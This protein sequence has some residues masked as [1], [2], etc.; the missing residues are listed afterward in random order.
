MAKVHCQPEANGALI[1]AASMMYAV[2][3]RPIVAFI[4]FQ[5]NVSS[6]YWMASGVLIPALICY[7]WVYVFY[8]IVVGGFAFTLMPKILLWV[9]GNRAKTAAAPEPVQTTDYEQ[10]L[11]NGQQDKANSWALFWL[12]GKKRGA[13][14]ESIANP[15]SRRRCNNPEKMGSGARSSAHPRDVQRG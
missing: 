8:A 15:E 5:S 2:M 12:C 13:I 1:D 9:M 10:A 6:A 14:C 4:I 7:I 11:P 3:P